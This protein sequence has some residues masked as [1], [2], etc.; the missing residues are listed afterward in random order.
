[1]NPP[2][3][4]TQPEYLKIVLIILLVA[5]TTFLHFATQES[6]HYYHIVLRELY[7]LPILLAAFWFGL[8][9]GLVSS[10]GISALYI[11]LVIMHWQAFSPEDL[12]KS[13]E[14][15]L[16]NVVALV[17]GVLS[18][19]EKK[20]EREKQEAILA[21]AGTI[22]HELNSP[23]QVVLGNSQFL[24]DDFEPESETYKELQTIIDNTKTIKQI[25]KKI[26]FLDRFTLKEY[27]GD[28]KIVDIS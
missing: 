21:M 25:V 28:A 8:R 2:N 1:M 5:I 12:D 23:L 16:L 14:I 6:Q 13:L 7:F 24:Q 3:K 10:L 11:P 17:M 9:G 26:S 4:Y 18:D 15:I 22:A 27:A 19:R 20:K